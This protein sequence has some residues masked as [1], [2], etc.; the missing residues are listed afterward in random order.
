MKEGLAQDAAVQAETWS[1]AIQC[2]EPE[3]LRDSPP[4]EGGGR[5]VPCACEEGF[6]LLASTRCTCDG[7]R[8]GEPF[9]LS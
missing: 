1:F 3:T 2:G 4:G 6:F 8:W 7:V 9:P 5:V